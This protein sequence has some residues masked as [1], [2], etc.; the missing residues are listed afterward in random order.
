MT[1]YDD[2]KPPPRSG[3]GVPIGWTDR[4][5]LLPQCFQLERQLYRIADRFDVTTDHGHGKFMQEM[6]V[7]WRDMTF[8]NMEYAANL[9]SI[10]FDE[11]TTHDTMVKKVAGRWLSKLIEHRTKSQLAYGDLVEMAP[12]WGSHTNIITD[13]TRITITATDLDGN[14]DKVQVQRTNSQVFWID[15]EFVKKIG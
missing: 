13:N 11:K 2:S 4:P 14:P 5:N 10:E 3:V 1:F 12:S 9:L 8:H 7:L 6:L 15:R